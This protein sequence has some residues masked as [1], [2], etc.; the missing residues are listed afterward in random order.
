M[1]VNMRAG[2]CVLIGCSS[3]FIARAAGAE[4]VEVPL[5]VDVR[6]LGPPLGSALGMDQE[7]RTLL[8]RDGCNR[9]TLSDL[10]VGIEG[11]RLY[12]SVATSA[13]TGNALLNRC[14][15][16][17]R[18]DGSAR[19][20][21][22]PTVAGDGLAI[23]LVPG[24][25][26]LLRPDGSEGLIGRAARALV[27]AL[28]LP[29]LSQ[30]RLDFDEL[31]VQIDALL[32]ELA[33]PE[34]VRSLRLID[35]SRLIA[36]AVLAEESAVS[37]S[38]SFDVEPP[39]ERGASVLPLDPAELAE[40]QRLEDE[41]DGFLTTIIVRLAARAQDPGLRLDL[42]G[43][44]LSARIAIA[45]ALAEDQLSTEGDPVRDLFVSS[46]EALRPHL[47]ALERA[48]PLDGVEGLKLAGF[49]AG[50]DAIRAVDA[51]GPE[52]GL[53]ITRDGLRRLARLLLADEAPAS[54]TPLP[55]EIDPALRELLLGEDANAVL[56]DMGDDD[57]PRRNAQ[58]R[59]NRSPPSE[60][61][62]AAVLRALLRWLV[63]SAH[64]DEPLSDL[65][66]ADLVPR[67]ADVHAY[68]E[69]IGRLLDDAIDAHLRSTRVP[70]DHRA[71]IPALIRATAWKESCWRQ[72]TG[73]PDNPRV[74]TSS[75]G[76]LGI[77][78]IH[79]RV[80]RGVYDLDRLAADIRYNIAAG[81]DILHHYLVDYA[82]R[83]GEHNQP[84]GGTES[85]VRATY[86]A[87]N[88]GP[89]HLSR[90]RQPDT[91]ARLSAI[92]REFWR[93]YQWFEENRRPDAAS[94]YPVP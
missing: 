11:D 48:A 14:V 4:Q 87:Y 45:E 6:H 67:V 79:G 83:R 82:I 59:S 61:Q 21:L 92:D 93:H 75:A 94:C 74:M 63:P 33:G 20:E 41:L 13:E 69:L 34:T 76:A 80:W 5:N 16:V 42:L 51:L 54:F 57:R 66:V 81:V 56:N 91:A 37:A 78:Q 71:G 77:M 72:F 24:A 31:L 88:G 32:L 40:W 12:V 55:L 1:E 25:L 10:D 35:R 7:G 36:A 47:R 90:Y 18:W 50:G 49:L 19:V 60:G 29:R 38:L 85:L 3:L 8:V 26:Q 84:P 70:D 27:A 15:G 39:L 43:V 73:T 52:F 2:V 17:L 22:T 86:S 30:A 9:I 65:N 23:A 64:A 53:E 46:W 58:R 28:V 62:D 44:L 68:L 89:S